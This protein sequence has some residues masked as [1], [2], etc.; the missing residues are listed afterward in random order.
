MLF[1]SNDA[2]YLVRAVALLEDELLAA[3]ES[4]V[5][6]RRD[7]ERLERAIAQ[8]RRRGLERLGDQ[9]AAWSAARDGRGLLALRWSVTLHRHA[10]LRVALGG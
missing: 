5:G 3:A 9:A 7:P 2:L 8:L 4:G 6:T 10:A 1:R